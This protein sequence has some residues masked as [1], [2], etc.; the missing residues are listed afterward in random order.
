M[1]GQ[2]KQPFP[3]A[4]EIRRCWDYGNWCEA[5]DALEGGRGLDVYELALLADLT[6]M[7]T[8]QLCQSGEIKGG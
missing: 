1:D 6:H 8:R 7:R 3:L 2:G 4:L 5:R